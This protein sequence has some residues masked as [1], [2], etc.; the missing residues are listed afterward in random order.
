MMRE[1]LH[2]IG[3]CLLVCATCLTLLGSA[4]A[5]PCCEG[6]TGNANLQG[7]IDLADLSLLIAY[8]TVQPPDRPSLPCLEE[9]NLNAAGSID[10]SDLSL[11][12][13][14]LTAPASNRPA[15]PECPPLIQFINLKLGDAVVNGTANLQDAAGAR[16]VLWAKT[17]RWYVQPTV[18]QPFTNIQSDGSWSNSTYPWN[19][20]VALLVEPGYVPGA[21]RDYHPSL[22]PGVISWTEFPSRSARDFNWS[23]WRWLVKK[24]AFA[25]PGPNSFSDDTAN[26]KI[27]SDNR[28]RLRI[29]YRSGV[30]H[31]AEVVLDHSLGY[32][33]YSFKID[34][35]VD[36][37]DFNVIFAGFIYD[38]VDKEF[39]MEFSQ[40]LANPFNAQYVVQPWYVPGNIVFYN[41]PASAQ[42]S[43]TFEWRSDRIVFTSWTGHD[44]S[45]APATL[46]STWTYTG[47][48][49]PLPGTERMRFNLYLFGGDLPV[50]GLE[51]EVIVRS[52]K[53]TE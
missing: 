2:Y 21:T 26:V 10:L 25:D 44:N 52:F 32:G 50:T 1:Y 33:V 15:L 16:V 46:I 14:F 22:D 11:L 29:D 8:L 38:V 41:M 30:W 35:R 24:E 4:A 23:G 27:D 7:G 5:S 37:L 42:T 9:A 3:A 43:H 40:R 6:T 13:A 53:F 28:L 45:P 31:C 34:S 51:D 12:V 20:M 48:N 19:R 36:S 49:I 39:D 17:D 47:G 18:A